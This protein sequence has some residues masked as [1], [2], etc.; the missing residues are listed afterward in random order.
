MVVNLKKSEIIVFRNGGPLRK[1]ERWVYRGE[2]I[3][4]T[5][6]YKFMGL[7]FTPKLS[8]HSA[9][10][11]L[12][13]QARKSLYQIKRFE[14]P[15][16]KFCH[17]EYFKIFDSMVIPILTYGSEIWGYDTKKCVEQIQTKFCKNFL[18]I[19]SS[20]NDA[21]ALG[22]CGRF[23]L[24]INYHIKFI[25]YWVRLIHMDP[26]RYPKQCY[27]M[28]KKYDDIGR[29]NWV[30]KVRE[31][32]FKYGFGFV[33]LSQ[34]IGNETY[35][36]K[37]VKQRLKDCSFQ[38]WH[39]DINT[40]SRC[41]LYKNVKTLLNVEKYLNLDIKPYYKRSL[42]R[43]RCSSHKLNVELGRHFNIEREN[44]ICVYCF[45]QKDALVIEDEFHAFFVCEKFKIIRDL[46]LNTWFNALPSLQNFYC[47]LQNENPLVI[48]NIAIY[49]SKLFEEI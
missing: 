15:F 49:V 31:F 17:K 34:D 43:F 11:K 42:S 30:T 35:F 5:S 8:W 12:A 44:R 24:A 36:I 14:K 45:M 2:H 9:T 20:V 28:L 22:E 13:A 25:K 18:G 48:K 33:W 37:Q 21:M 32:L 40:S 26:N 47:L 29:I 23:P 3:K 6:T 27:L 4:V 39:N 7:L 38:M 41:D 10:T 1:Y 19:N 16:G 46:Y